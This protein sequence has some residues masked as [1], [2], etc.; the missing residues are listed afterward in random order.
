MTPPCLCQSVLDR[1]MPLQCLVPRHFATPLLFIA[2][3]CL[4]ISAPGFAV[5]CHRIAVRNKAAPL[6]CVTNRRC[7]FANLFVALPLLCPCSPGSAFAYLFNALPLPIIALLSQST[8]LRHGASHLLCRE[9]PR[10]AIANLRQALLFRYF[11]FAALRCASRFRAM[12]WPVI[13]A[14]L[15]AFAVHCIALPLLC[16]QSRSELREIPCQFI[17]KFINALMRYVTA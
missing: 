14:L 7:A 13:A 4:C 1:A 10:Q 5:Q 11:A 17:T 8:A 16:V 2:L 15:C 9:L 6:P 12:P 3:L